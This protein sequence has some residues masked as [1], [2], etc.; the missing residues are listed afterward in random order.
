[1]DNKRDFIK[2]YFLLGIKYPESYIHGWVDQTRGYWN[3]LYDYP[4][5]YTGV[6][7]NTFGASIIV[8]NSWLNTALSEY[9][10]MF[11]NLKVL[12]LFMGIGV[13]VWLHIVAVFVG[14]IRR[15][16][17]SILCAAVI[18]F[19]LISLLVATPVWSEYRYI[20]AAFC[21]M[22]IVLAITLR[23]MQKSMKN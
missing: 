17:I 16:K 6:H 10:W 4:A 14:L 23:P 2:L 18:I 1:M 7:E 22:P 5:I 8:K 13:F 11:S 15:D 21:T 20:Y 12:Q 9:I 3:A 19:L